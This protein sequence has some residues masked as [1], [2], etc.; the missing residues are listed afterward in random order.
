M[1]ISIATGPW[2][3]VPTLQGGAAPRLWQGLAE[4]FAAQGHHV[5]IV[6]RAY[7]G[8]PSTETINGVYYQRRGGFPQS[9]NI[10]SDLIKDLI[11]A[12]STFHTLPCADILVINDFWL[13][14]FAPLQRRI[15]KTVISVGRFPKGQYG[16]Y[17]RVDQ[18]AVLTQAIYEEISRQHPDTISRIRIIPNPVD[19]HLFYPP[20]QPKDRKDLEKIILYVGRIHP[21]KGIDRLI[22]A[23]AIMSQQVSGVRLRIIGPMQETQGGGGERYFNNLKLKAKGFDIEFYAPIFDPQKLADAYREADLFCYPSLAE[24]GEAFPVAPL[25]AMATGLVPV[26]S[27]LSCFKNYIED[28]QTG[29]YFDHRG[30]DASQRLADVLSLAIL[31]WEKTCQMSEKATQ[32]ALNYSYEKVARLYL[33]NFQELLDS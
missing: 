33:N 8:Q 5:T 4:A 27:D 24:K 6:C 32:A 19:T 21:E 12:L 16:L 7:S 10:W 23:F 26:V 20:I 1:K 22:E 9:T 25:E 13:P 14:V 30:A 28:N 18:F 11:Y 15:R 31:N 3:P 17:S 29:Y 2:L